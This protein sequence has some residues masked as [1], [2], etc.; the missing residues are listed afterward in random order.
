[1]SK[2]IVNVLYAPGINC[3][4]ELLDAFKLVGAAP[5]LVLLTDDLIKRKIR[6]AECD[7]LA[8]PGGF[9]FGDH[10]AAGRIFAL[11]LINHLIDELQ[12][13]RE[14]QKLIIGICNGFQVL[15]NTG[16][17]P[18]TGKIGE[19]NALLDRNESALFESRWTDVV[20]KPSPCIWTKGLEGRLL[21]IPSAHGEGR[22][23]LPSNF[24][25]ANTALTYDNLAGDAPYPFN[26]NGSEKGRA[27]ICDPSG[28]ILGLMPHPERAIYPWLGSEDRLMIFKTG[29]KAVS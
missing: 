20:V 28:L 24:D 2:P 15:I 29:V 13:L 7:I 23:K 17:L 1:M 10:I 19:P 8:I 26:P 11:D 22:L 5:R 4:E 25:D 18:G 14:K 12:E 3:H 27:G 21:R 16:L 9:S 6:L